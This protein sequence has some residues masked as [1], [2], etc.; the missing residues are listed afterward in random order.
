MQ[1]AFEQYRDEM[2]EATENIEMVT[3]DKEMAEEKLD[4]LTS[5]LESLREQVEELT[6]ENQIL[7]N[8]QELAA[9]EGGMFL[10]AVRVDRHQ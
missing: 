8:E 4:S 3:L 2:A 9:D 5:E 10:T 1:Q 7:K 6:L